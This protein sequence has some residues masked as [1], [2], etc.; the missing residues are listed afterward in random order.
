[1]TGK[2][3]SLDDP[4][5]RGRVQVRFPWMDSDADHHWAPIATLLAGGGRGS[6]FMPEKHDDVLVA[7]EH[8]HMDHPYIIGC[9]WNGKAKPPSDGK[10]DVRRIKTVCGHVIE[11]NDT[12]DAHQI[13]IKTAGG[14][15]I[16][17]TDKPSKSIHVETDGGQI[18]DL[19]DKSASVTLQTD[20]HQQIELTDKPAQV[21]ITTAAQNSISI[22]DSPAGITINAPTGML[23]VNCM[24]ATLNP[25]SL[26]A[27]NAPMAIFSGTVIA[28]TLVAG[29][30]SSATYTPGVG[31]TMGL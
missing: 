12:K 28:T 3:V 19:D 16:E 7:F 10:K 26:L 8:G 6:W 22:S 25:T 27:V 5:D 11:F 2:V 31:N 29:T 17:L 21:S 15:S 30:I 20:G 24:Q 18:V 4:E 23:N 13:L 9:L 1:V 14:S